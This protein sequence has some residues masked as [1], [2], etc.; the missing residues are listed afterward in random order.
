[1]EVLPDYEIKRLSRAPIISD[2]DRKLYFKLDQSVETLIKQA[3]EPHNKIGLWLSYIYFKVSGRFYHQKKF[4]SHD[5]GMAAKILGV[6][7]TKDFST[8]YSDRTRQKHRLLILEH[9]G[10]TEFSKAADLF[11]NI[12]QDLVASQ[13]YPR[14][15]FYI[16][17]ETLRNKKIEAPSYDRIARSVTQK[18]NA[19]EKAALQTI[20]RMITSEQAEALNQLTSTPKEEYQRPLLTRLKVFNQS[21]RP[22]QIKHGMHNFLIIK[23][24]FKEI[25]PIIDSLSFSI[26]ATKYYAQWVMKAKVTQITDMV[27]P[28]KRYLYLAAFVDHCYK[29]WQDTLVDM[30]LKCVQQQ[31][32]KVEKELGNIIKEK[33]SDKNKLV[34]SVLSGFQANQATIENVRKILHDKSLNNDT[35]IGELCLLVPEQSTAIQA[36][37]D[38]EKLKEH[39]AF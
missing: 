21:L 13:M 18:F 35:K 38:A 20:S 1:M 15:L 17:I 32:N 39:L 31:L 19:F 26:E 30:L 4:R 10:Y 2:E 3:K 5:I 22:A 6:T 27:V 24:L 11:E 25:K 23:K 29:V 34:T 9:C 37:N 14:K 36:I 16:L 33:L 12:V 8:Q 7:I 28:H